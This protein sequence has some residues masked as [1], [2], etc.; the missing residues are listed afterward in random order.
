VTALG[1]SL[2]VPRAFFP[3]DLLFATC[4]TSLSLASENLAFASILYCW[5]LGFKS[6][7]DRKDKCMQKKG[8]NEINAAYFSGTSDFCSRWQAFPYGNIP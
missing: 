3:L 8:V 5:V 6:T 4:A 2:L 7:E 1:T